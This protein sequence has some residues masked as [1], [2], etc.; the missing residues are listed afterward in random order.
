MQGGGCKCVGSIQCTIIQFNNELL[1]TYPLTQT[2]EGSLVK[3]DIYNFVLLK[4]VVL[5]GRFRQGERQLK[6]SAHI[7]STAEM[8]TK[9]RK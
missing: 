7:T 4:D 2:T 1:I 8:Q 5:H 6:C 3:K 9:S